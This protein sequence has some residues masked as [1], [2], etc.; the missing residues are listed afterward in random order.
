MHTGVHKPNHV[1][2]DVLQIGDSHDYSECLTD[3]F[4]YNGYDAVD[5]FCDWLFQ[6]KHS[7]TTVIAHNQAGYDGTFILQWCLKKGLHPQKYI[8]Q[9][10]RIMYMDFVKYHKIC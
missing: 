9:G 4:S 5:K 8:R 6:P 2:A 1:E 7:H 3:T 10:G